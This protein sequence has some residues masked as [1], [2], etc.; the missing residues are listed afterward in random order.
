MTDYLVPG[1]RWSRRDFLARMAA[2]TGV[3]AGRSVGTQ[4]G[5]S[6]QPGRL[7]APRSTC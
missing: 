3:A 4:R 1:A 7:T 2:A 5:F 6:G